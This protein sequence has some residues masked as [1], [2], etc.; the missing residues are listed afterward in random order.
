LL[1]LIT[2]HLFCLT[3]RL[4]LTEAIKK[5]NRKQSCLPALGSLAEE[6]LKCTER[7]NIQVGYT[8]GYELPFPQWLGFLENIDLWPWRVRTHILCWVARSLCNSASTATKCFHAHLQSDG[9]HADGTSSTYATNL[10]TL[11]I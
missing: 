9:S 5:S 3:D 8:K 4:R 2:K 6:E 1:I 11:R 7:K 10:F